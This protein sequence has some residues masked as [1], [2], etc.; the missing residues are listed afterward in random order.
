MW[1]RQTTEAATKRLCLSFYLIKL[2]VLL[3]PHLIK[4]RLQHPCFPLNIEKF[5]RRPILE[6]NCEPPVF[7][8]FL[9][10]RS[11]TLFENGLKSDSYLPKNLCSLLEWNSFK[12][13]EKC[14]LFYFKGS[15]RSQL[16]VCLGILVMQKKRLD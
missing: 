2:P 15:C 7:W 14:F 5:L 4:K 1:I 10:Y 12:K 11:W 16:N 9:M 3:R 13:D 8:C 6:N